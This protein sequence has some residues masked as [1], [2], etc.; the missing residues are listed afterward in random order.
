M[1][2]SLQ[3]PS[4]AHSR[5]V[6]ALCALA[7]AALTSACTS[8]A[9]REH[10]APASEVVASPSPSSAPTPAPNAAADLVGSLDQRPATLAVTVGAVQQGVPPL[11]TFGGMLADACHLAPD[12]TEYA[13]VSVRFGTPWQATKRTGDSA[14]LRVDLA[15][16]GGSG[17]GILVVDPDGATDYCPGLSALPAQATLQTEN[18]SDEH[19]TMTVY[20]LARTAAGAA[21]PLHGVTL[22]LRDLRHHP[23]DIDA[24]AWTWGVQ[25]L[26]AGSACPGDPNS[27]CVPLR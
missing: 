8:A 14:N 24:G 2:A 23:D 6:V 12:A 5:A 16:S 11:Q 9:A 26:T 18:L 3:P 1:R 15:L 22:Q 19:Q 7:V 25:R 10:A 27:L 20:V 13:P 21:D 17:A 4:C